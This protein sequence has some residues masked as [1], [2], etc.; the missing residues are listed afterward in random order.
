MKEKG[1]RI[2]GK[3]TKSLTG[4]IEHL[5]KSIALMDYRTGRQTK[6]LI[7]VENRAV[8]LGTAYLKHRE[9][10]MMYPNILN[11]PK[12]DLELL[13][14]LYQYREIQFHDPIVV[15]LQ[16]VKYLCM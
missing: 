6:S 1:S 16:V 11:A 10:E 3:E 2:D 12:T 9:H 15:S 13:R 14:A 4:R 7:D 5:L 8:F